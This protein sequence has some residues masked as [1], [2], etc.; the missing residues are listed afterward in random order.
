MLIQMCNILFVVLKIKINQMQQTSKKQLLF[1]LILILLQRALTA[2]FPF[3]VDMNNSFNISYENKSI[4]GI[5]DNRAGNLLVAYTDA[6]VKVYDKAFNFLYAFPQLGI[7][8][9]LK[10]FLSFKMTDTFTYNSPS[11]TLIT[12][13]LSGGHLIAIQPTNTQILIFNDPNGTLVQ[14]KLL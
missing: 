11:N 9:T 7:N 8:I 13:K 14:H 1:T 6:S 2:Q 12:L 5:G 3:I 4:T 10:S